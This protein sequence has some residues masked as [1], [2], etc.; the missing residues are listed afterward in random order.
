MD[1]KKIEE[2]LAGI[3]IRPT[4]NRIL[5]LRTL[6][7]S[8]CPLSLSDLEDKLYPADKSSIFRVLN[9]LSARGIVHTIDDGSG[10]T[11]YEVCRHPGE[12]GPEE[13]HVHFF[14]ETCRRTFC[15]PSQKVPQ[16]ALPD[17]FSASKV[18]LTVKGVCNECNNS[19]K[20]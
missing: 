13:E 12:C 9:I 19:N 11:K 1:N 17:G 8:E 7:G 20:S 15:I 6:M 3:G 5:V 16:V 4:A 2:F 10:S 14:C 18:S